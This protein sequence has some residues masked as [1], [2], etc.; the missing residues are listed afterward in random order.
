VDAGRFMSCQY[1]RT[2]GILHNGHA[3]AFHCA[4]FGFFPNYAENDV[5]RIY[6]IAAYQTPAMLAPFFVCS[7]FIAD[8]V[9][10]RE[11]RNILN[12][13]KRVPESRNEEG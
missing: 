12:P 2:R 7:L 4:S 8:I 5:A 11:K 3:L 10:T 13:F 9:Q 1:H 6:E